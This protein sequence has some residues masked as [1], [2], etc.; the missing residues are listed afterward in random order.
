MTRAV[1]G[2]GPNLQPLALAA[3]M[4]LE[5]DAH[6]APPLLLL[7][8]RPRRVSLQQGRCRLRPALVRFGLH[9]PQ[10][11]ILM[12]LPPQPLLELAHARRDQGL[13]AHRVNAGSLE[14]C[15][16]AVALSQ[17]FGDGRLHPLQLALE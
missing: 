10:P 7:T 12:H 5:A 4:C 3:Q 11:A 6:L 1:A 2:S 15:V 17:G 8:L 13:L 9:E 16:H 14:H